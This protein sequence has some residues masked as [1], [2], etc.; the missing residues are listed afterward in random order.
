MHGGKAAEQKMAHL[1][2]ERVVPDLPPFINVGVDCFG[3]IIVRR[4]RRIVKQYRVVFSCMTS[5]AVH[6]EVAYSLD[7]DSCISALR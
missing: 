3:P 5:R 7:K 6:L 4:G 2:V 1:P